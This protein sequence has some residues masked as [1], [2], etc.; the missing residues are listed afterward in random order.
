M[1]AWLLEARQV[2]V[3]RDGR[4]ILSRIDLRIEPGQSVALTGPS[5]S[6]KT[7]L[8]AVLAGLQAPDRGQVHL[9]GVD[10]A[11]L[12]PADRHRR[13]GI[14]FQGY[15]LL[16]LLTAAENVELA[17]QVQGAPRAGVPV[18]AAAALAAVG[19]G[20]RGGHLVE[21]LSGGEQQRV[22]VARALVAEPQLVLA[23]EPTAELD[24]A[25]RALVLA[26]LL[27]VAAAGGTLI[28]ATHDDGVA[29][30]CERQ[31]QLVDGVLTAVRDGP[32][33]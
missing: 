1:T 24:E 28:L 6:G 10:L 26:E 15:G 14:V 16:S 11:D 32:P 21:E 8:L 12:D 23:D 4:D 7:T 22:A 25:T 20:D 29:A 2:S 30:A 31:F 3:R 27:Q 9:G 33:D 19:L 5:G 18:R 17:L 13:L